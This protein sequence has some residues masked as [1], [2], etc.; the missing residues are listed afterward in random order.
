MGKGPAAVDTDATEGGLQSTGLGTNS[1]A[2]STSGEGAA[3]SSSSSAA[4]GKPFKKPAFVKKLTQHVATRWYRAPELILLQPYTNAVDIWAAGCIFAEL[5]S[6]HEDH[7]DPESGGIKSTKN[8][9]LMNLGLMVLNI[10]S[11][12]LTFT[13][14]Q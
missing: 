1:S 13:L 2:S 8:H 12:F 10:S 6:V 5:L 11:S 9:R 4:G 7:V 14:R 3:G